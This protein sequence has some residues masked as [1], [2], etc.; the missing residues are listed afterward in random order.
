MI[1]GRY[2]AD[3]DSV[4]RS[5]GV[6]APTC[7]A[8]APTPNASASLRGVTLAGRVTPAGTFSFA[9]A[10]RVSLSGPIVRDE[11]QSGSGIDS[12][13]DP[14]G[15]GVTVRTFVSA[16]PG[17]QAT[18]RTE[19]G[20]VTSAA[21]TVTL[22]RGTGEAPDRFSASWTL[23]TAAGTVTGT[24]RGEA[25]LAGGVWEL[26]GRTIYTGGTWNV[27][28]GSGGFTAS[29]ATNTPGDDSDDAIS[30]QIDGLVAG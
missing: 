19:T 29:L 6:G 20:A 28:S 12:D 13:L 4:A 24:A 8:F 22:S 10:N 11:P 9:P 17:V 26:R 15:G 2:V 27:A 14:A 16:S 18:S 1:G 3:A 25:I 30:W 23:A 21:I 5:P 7:V